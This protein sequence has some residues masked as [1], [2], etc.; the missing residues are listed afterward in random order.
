[1]NFYWQSGSLT[2]A[3]HI[4]L[5]KLN[6]AHH[7]SNLA[8]GALA[9]EVWEEQVKDKELPGLCREVEN[10]I[11]ALG[12]NTDELEKVSKW[13]FKIQTKKYIYALNREQLLEEIRNSKKLSY[14]KLSQEQ[15]ERK[16]YFFQQNLENLRILFQVS[17]HLVPYLKANY[18]SKE[19]WKATHLSILS[20]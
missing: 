17:S 14:E 16:Q 19:G 2:F 20:C 12:F 10:H 6:F 18:P 8:E 11:S 15:F 3:N 5:R 1:M 4:L 9:R 13:Q 7:L